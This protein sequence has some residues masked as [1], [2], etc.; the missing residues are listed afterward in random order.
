MQSVAPQ[1]QN[2]FSVWD[3]GTDNL[4]EIWDSNCKSK[5]DEDP[6]SQLVDLMGDGEPLSGT[7]E[8]SG[9]RPQPLLSFDD[10]IDGTFCATGDL[11][12]PQM[13]LSYQHALQHVSSQEPDLE[14]G[15]LLMTNGDSLLKEGTQVTH[16]HWTINNGQTLGK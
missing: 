15:Q 6:S 10:M 8:A 11:D 12:E 9:A 14:D 16:L 4:V 1:P 2:S 13:T 3:S 7:A 5:P